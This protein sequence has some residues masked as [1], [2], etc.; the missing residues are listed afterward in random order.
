[1]A[2]LG[3][4]LEPGARGDIVGQGMNMGPGSNLDIGRF[5]NYVPDY[6][7]RFLPALPTGPGSSPL[8]QPDLVPPDLMKPEDVQMIRALTQ[9]IGGSNGL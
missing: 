8:P 3:Q 6:E 2:R 5:Y 1:M 7:P 4:F 9:L